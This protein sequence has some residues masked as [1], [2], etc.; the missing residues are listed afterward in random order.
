MF[1]QK[2]LA[3]DTYAESSA[4]SDGH[5]AGCAVAVIRGERARSLH[6][7]AATAHKC[8]FSIDGILRLEAPESGRKRS[9]EVITRSKTRPTGRYPSWKMGRMIDWESPHELNAFRLLDADAGVIAF[10]EQ[11]LRV[12]YVLNGEAHVHYPD[13][14]V[15]RREGARDGVQ[16]A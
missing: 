14:A 16:K 1:I 3:G 4:I 7:P 10:F 13:I 5:D 11:P 9:R 8:R 2:I 6:V 15:L 12:H